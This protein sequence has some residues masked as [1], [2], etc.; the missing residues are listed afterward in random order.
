[1]KWLRRNLVPVFVLMALS[2]TG[3]GAV[4]HPMKGQPAPSFDLRSLS[5][6]QIRNTDY[7]GE[8]VVLHFGAG[9]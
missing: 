9:W 7:L 4:E 1:M 6:D 8:I 3:L 5:G 2:A